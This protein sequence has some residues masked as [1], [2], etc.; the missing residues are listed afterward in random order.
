M[1]QPWSGILRQ[2]KLFGEE[3]GGALVDRQGQP[4]YITNAK[5]WPIKIFIVVGDKAYVDDWL[6]CMQVERTLNLW[7]C[8]DDQLSFLRI[9][10]KIIARN[11]PRALTEAQLKALFDEFVCRIL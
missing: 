10:M 1:A 9:D 8:Y 2:D 11:L 6:A 5:V 4:F 7:V 3:A